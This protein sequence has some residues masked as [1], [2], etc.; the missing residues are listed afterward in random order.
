M[1][2]L[3]PDWP[4]PPG[5]QAAMSTRAG[6]VSVAPFDS[7][8]LSVGVGDDPAAV[9][10]NRARWT[11]ALGHPPVWLHLVHGREVLRLH[12]GGPEHPAT[13]ADAAWTTDAGV[14]CQVSA[15]DCLPVLFALRDG[16]A[17][18]AAHAGWRGLAAGVLEATVQAICQGTGAAPDGVLAWLG[19][20]IGPQAFEVG[21]EVLQAFG[22]KPLAGADAGAPV[23]AGPHFISRPRADGSARWLANL[24]ALAS[25]RLQAAGVRCITA[26]GLC[27]VADASRFF[28]FR[29]DGRTG[30]LAASIWREHGA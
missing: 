4:A 7:L 27:T 17:V 22:C 28:S 2:L 19:P 15:A 26:S 3:R 13:W 6:G 29:R 18:G 9:A 23:G 10:E 20:C 8:N 25:D 1:P 30:R 14:V 21:A 24:P 5:V 12:R 16:R 11:A